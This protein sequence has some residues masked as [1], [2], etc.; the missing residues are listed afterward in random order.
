MITGSACAIGFYMAWSIGAN[1]VANAM[2]TAVG[3]KAISYK[4]AVIARRYSKFSW[5]VF[6]LDPHVT[7][8]IKGNIVNPVGHLHQIFCLLDLH[9]RS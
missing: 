9:P 5:C 7:E 8:T 6:A 4:Q 3:A 1:D 2:A